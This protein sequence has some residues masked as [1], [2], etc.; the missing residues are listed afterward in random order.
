MGVGA[1]ASC[2]WA[3]G[4]GG[5][6]GGSLEGRVRWVGWRGSVRGWGGVGEDVEVMK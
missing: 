2:G 1:Q 6:I 4:L 5:G 3:G